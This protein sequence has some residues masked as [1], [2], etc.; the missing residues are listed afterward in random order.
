MRGDSELLADL[1][2]N[3]GNIYGVTGKVPEA[4]VYYKKA[5][6]I[7]RREEDYS[8][9]G[10]TFVN[11]GNL[12]SDQGNLDQAVHHYKQGLLL[13]EQEGRWDELSTLYGNLSLLAVKRADMASSETYA[14]K[15]LASA[16]RLK[17]PERM[18]DA[19]HRLAK[20]KDANGKLVE[21]KRRSESANALYSQL[22]N[23]M[24]C[25]MTL[26]HQTALYEKMGDGQGAIDCLSQVVAI[27]EKYQLPK[28]EENKKRLK[29]L[30]EKI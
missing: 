26:Y 16:E 30:R 12:Y 10:A 1:Y 24:G 7:L 9:L 19:L 8:R 25:A 28:L 18:A 22:R 6:E 14:E 3:L 13:L 27:D 4:I 23:E 2:G 11:I 15:G 29:K 5:V 17:R 20:A 21:A